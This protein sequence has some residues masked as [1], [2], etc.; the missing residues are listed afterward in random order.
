[1]KKLILLALIISFPTVLY[2]QSDSTK[3]MTIKS[4]LDSIIIKYD[5]KFVDVTSANNIKVGPTTNF[6][7]Q[8]DFLIAGKTYY[9]NLNRLVSFWVGKTIY[10]TDRNCLSLV[11]N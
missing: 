4:Q 11:F 7:I 2:C 1:M 8:N 9:F 6:K 3:F 5:V 10:S